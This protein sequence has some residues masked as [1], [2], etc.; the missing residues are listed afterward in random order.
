MF[1]I[2]KFAPLILLSFG[3]LFL[4]KR[5]IYN[6]VFLGVIG[7]LALETLSFLRIG[8]KE[9]ASN[10]TLYLSGP[11]YLLLIHSLYSRLFFSLFKKHVFN[12]IYG[13]IL[14]VM[15]V[16]VLFMY[17]RDINFVFHYSVAIELIILAYPATYFVKLMN[18]K[19]SYNV[20]YFLLNSIVFLFFSLEIILYVMLKF[21]LDEDL[22]P[23]MIGIAYFRFFIIQLLY[24]SLIYFGCTLKKQPT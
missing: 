16:G 17:D 10:W 4:L 14:L 6:G 18:Q 19:V 2:I 5:K 23:K 21:I 7:L 3:V 11:I 13:V 15:L 9:G 1:S 24:I 8:V 12:M 22:F 20:Q